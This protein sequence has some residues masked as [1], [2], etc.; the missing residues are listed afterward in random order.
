MLQR[1]SGTVYSGQSSETVYAAPGHGVYAA[2]QPVAGIAM[3]FDDT[4]VAET[5]HFMRA[6]TGEAPAH[7]TLDDAVASATALEAMVTS[8]N[9]GERVDL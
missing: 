5:M 9:S 3:G 8:S 1:S 4:K 6:I 2:D 7:A